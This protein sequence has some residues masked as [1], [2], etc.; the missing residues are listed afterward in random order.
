M[1][2][3]F[4]ILRKNTKLCSKWA[5]HLE[6]NGAEAGSTTALWKKSTFFVP[7]PEEWKSA[8]AYG[9]FK[10]GS[11]EFRDHLGPSMV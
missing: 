1:P 6:Y 3:T 2:R 5:R 10:T 11:L 4:Q 9:C 8:P 7:W